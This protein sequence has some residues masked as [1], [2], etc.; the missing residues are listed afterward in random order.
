MGLVY[1]PAGASARLKR[2]A[3]VTC[4]PIKNPDDEGTIFDSFFSQGLTEWQTDRIEQIDPELADA[5]R[6][7]RGNDD[8]S[9]L[10]QSKNPLRGNGL[11]GGVEQG[12][13]ALHPLLAIY[14]SKEDVEVFER[15]QLDRL[16][17]HAASQRPRK[18]F[19]NF[20]SSLFTRYSRDSGRSSKI[21]PS[22][23]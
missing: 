9:W 8:R 7:D 18:S 3:K 14:P 11:E 13:P 17:R 4:S 1:G 23:S 15:A 12:P 21:T 2:R 6:K 20:L 16:E 10:K 22:G 19:R 5:F